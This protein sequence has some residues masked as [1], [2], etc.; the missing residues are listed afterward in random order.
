MK[1]EDEW[2]HVAVLGA[3]G[4]MGKGIALLLLQEIAATE[5]AKLTLVDT[6]A[7]GFNGLK[8]YLR[9]H[10]L[11]HAEKNINGLRLLYGSRKDLIDNGEMIQEFVERGL[12]K[13]RCVTSIDECRGAQMIFEA[14]IEDVDIKAKTLAKVKEMADP[15]AY[16][17]SNTSSIPIQVLQEKSRTDGRLVGFHFYN[18]PAVQKLLEVIIPEHTLDDTRAFALSLGQRLNKT[19]IFSQDIAGFIG[20]GHF[21]R[22]I[23]SACGAVD[24]IKREMSLTQAIS[25]VDE[26]F[27]KRLLRPMGIFQLIDYVG[28][29]VC[30]HI[31]RIM[32]KYL[33]GHHFPMPL[34][35]AMEARGIVG[36][37]HEDGSQKDGFF[38]YEKGRPSKVYDLDQAKYIPYREVE[39]SPMEA[40]LTWKY[41]SQDPDRREKISRYLSSLHND[42]S[43]S[44]KLA[45]QFL[46]KSRHIAHELVR[47][48]VASSIEDVDTVLQNGFFH[49]YGVDE[50]S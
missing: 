19:I 15:H 39:T 35:D 36:G 2:K 43:L 31:A 49:L 45:L 23:V 22:E 34:V 41:L 30:R 16:Y 7:D 21:I 20:N 10:L 32:A 12:D 38:S 27:R 5:D 11:R 48:G 50:T 40:T 14:I 13:V 1:A 17:F 25:L 26:I 24:S 3:A 18:P 46:E 42:S 28:I 44:G 37:Q 4:K 29:D 47:D 33:P 6:N 8:T 9:H